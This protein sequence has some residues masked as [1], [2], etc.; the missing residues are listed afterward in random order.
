MIELGE[1][2]LR[3]PSGPVRI[4]PTREGELGV[5]RLFSFPVKFY[6]DCPTCGGSWWT[7]SSE[8]IWC[9]DCILLPRCGDI[10]ARQKSR[11]PRRAMQ[12]IWQKDQ[13][14]IIGKIHMASRVFY[15]LDVPT[16][17]NLPVPKEPG[18][19]IT[20]EDWP[21]LRAAYLAAEQ[22][23][24][25]PARRN[26][27]PRTMDRLRAVTDDM[28]HAKEKTRKKISKKKQRYAHIPTL[29]FFDN[30]EYA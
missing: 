5:P 4:V 3:L 27:M 28:R 9:S 12:Q 29:G 19:S 15:P 23:G 22:A 7:A 25:I 2:E 1:L 13:Y 18:P 16:A 10:P 6:H 14:V 17:I 20:E 11:D 30:E 21:R 24:I 26:G 8:V